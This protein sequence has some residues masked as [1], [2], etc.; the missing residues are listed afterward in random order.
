LVF[1]TLSQHNIFRG[2]T[3]NTPRTSLVFETIPRLCKKLHQL[4]VMVSPN[5]PDYTMTNIL[6]RGSVQA[7]T[8]TKKHFDRYMR[9]KSLTGFQRTVFVHGRKIVIIFVE[10][11]F[12]PGNNQEEFKICL[13]IVY[14]AKNN[15]YSTKEEFL[16]SFGTDAYETL[17]FAAELLFDAACTFELN[18]HK[19]K[20]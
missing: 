7:E 12:I 1:N 14:G 16:L 4:S 8:I 5:D 19:D 10:K 3:M 17:D 20:N 18:A 6:L 15:I 13:R 9:K 11:E 2:K